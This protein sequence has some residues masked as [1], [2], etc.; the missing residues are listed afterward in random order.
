[1]SEDM[2]AKY[3]RRMFEVKQLVDCIEARPDLPDDWPGEDGVRA[4]ED[5]YKAWAKSAADLLARLRQERSTIN[6]SPSPMPR[7]GRDG[8]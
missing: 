5:A 8:E 3:A 4:F 2:E 1:M 6:P 7:N